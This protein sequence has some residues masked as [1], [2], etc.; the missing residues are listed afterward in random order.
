MQPGFDALLVCAVPVFL[1]A[2]GLQPLGGPLLHFFTTLSFS[3][4]TRLFPQPPAWFSQPFLAWLFLPEPGAPA[5]PVQ[6]VFWL[7]LKMRCCS[8]ASSRA[9]SSAACLAFSSAAWRPV[10]FAAD[11]LPPA[12]LAPITPTG[13]SHPKD[14][15]QASLCSI[16]HQQLIQPT[17]AR[18]GAG[19]SCVPG[20]RLQFLPVSASN[21]TTPNAYTSDAGRR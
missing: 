16:L 13:H 17:P 10:L 20:A 11:V 12:Q 14:A 3:F 1:S 7:Q 5:L 15:G 19:C 4:Q 2:V 9:F 21:K 8:S 18:P 6:L